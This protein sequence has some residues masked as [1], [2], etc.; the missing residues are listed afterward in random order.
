MF[1]KEVHFKD[2]P[3]NPDQYPFNLPAFQ[4][5]TNIFFDHTVTFLVG[6]NGS[7]KS[8]LLEAIAICAGFNPEGGSRSNTFSSANTES[9]LHSHLKLSWLPK[10][11]HGFFLRA[12]S[13]FNFASHIDEVEKDNPPERRYAAIW[14]QVPAR[15]IPWAIIFSPVH[16]SIPGTQ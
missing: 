4:G 5:L 12:E 13:F 6:E 1:L 2:W 10:V 16:S 7:G 3:A 14:R 9:I 15:A 11:T 8:T